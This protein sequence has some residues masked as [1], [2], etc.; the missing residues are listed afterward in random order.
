MPTLNATLADFLTKACDEKLILTAP[1][2]K[3]IFKLGLAA[4]RQTQR[5]VSSEDTLR[6]TW[7]P[8]TWD[9]LHKKIAS[10]ERFKGST[11][12][13]TMCLQMVKLSQGTTSPKKSK[14]TKGEPSVE[15]AAVKRKADINGDED[16]AAMRKAKRKKIKAKA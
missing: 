4:V 7:R 10:S 2:M 6:T 9:T 13:Q 1:Q 5:V 11:A 12:L 3:D 15:S 8:S 16:A 14:A